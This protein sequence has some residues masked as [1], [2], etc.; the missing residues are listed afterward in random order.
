MRD[1]GAKAFSRRAARYGIGKSTPQDR[2]GGQ[3]AI[4]LAPELIGDLIDSLPEIDTDFIG[5]L[6]EVDTD[7]KL[8]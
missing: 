4:V 3:N 2:P 8:P 5:S 1:M 6:P 7:L